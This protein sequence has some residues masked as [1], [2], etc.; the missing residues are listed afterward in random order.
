MP[1]DSNLLSTGW[2]VSILSRADEDRLI[3][4]V[5]ML[6]GIYDSRLYDSSTLHT[7]LSDIVFE[8]KPRSNLSSCYRRES[9]ISWLNCCARFGVYMIQLLIDAKSLT[10][11]GSL[12][13]VV[14][15]ERSPTRLE[16][17]YATLGMVHS[18]N[19]SGSR[20]SCYETMTMTYLSCFLTK[21]RAG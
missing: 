9:R 2:R 15:I 3:I 14:S 10:F 1:D 21:K 16:M 18:F 20:A 4:A 8:E 19:K 12:P 13:F 6:H 7:L 5:V 17:L 11:S